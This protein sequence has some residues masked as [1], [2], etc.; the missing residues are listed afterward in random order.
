VWDIAGCV[1]GGIGR[2]VVE[3]MGLKEIGIVRAEKREDI[4]SYV[5]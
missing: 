2:C 1:S 5:V 3:G 4:P